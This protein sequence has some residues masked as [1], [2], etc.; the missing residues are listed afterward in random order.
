MERHLQ[1]Q[2]WR[3]C[4][5]AVEGLG[6]HILGQGED[7]R[8]QSERAFVADVERRMGQRSEDRATTINDAAAHIH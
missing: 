2:I 3:R 6:L 5:R 8:I 4:Y 7:D 1:Q